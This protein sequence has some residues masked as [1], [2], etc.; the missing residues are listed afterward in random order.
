MVATP[1]PSS[2]SEAAARLTTNVSSYSWTESPL[3]TTLMV[4][5][6]GWPVPP[7]ML[8]VAFLWT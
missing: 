3:T 5:D 7:P 4:V 1:C 8:R 6:V 2:G